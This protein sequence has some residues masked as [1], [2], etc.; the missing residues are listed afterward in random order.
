M[1]RDHMVKAHKEL[2][3]IQPVASYQDPGR[4]PVQPK[5]LYHYSQTLFVLPVCRE[6]LGRRRTDGLRHLPRQ[7]PTQRI[8]SNPNFAFSLM[9]LQRHPHCIT[10]K[11]TPLGR[12]ELMQAALMAFAL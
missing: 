4:R 6:H 1:V 12:S 8:W 7:G 9:D 5:N 10:A 11:I 2:Q 3:H